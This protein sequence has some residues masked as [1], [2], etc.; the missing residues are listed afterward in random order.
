MNPSNNQQASVL[1][2]L[3]ILVGITTIIFL[4]LSQTDDKFNFINRWYIVV[5]IGVVYLMINWVRTY[6]LVL[7]FFSKIKFF[8]SIQVEYRSGHLEFVEKYGSKAVFNEECLLKKIKRKRLYEGCITATGNILEEIHT[9]NCFNSLNHKKDKITIIYGKKGTPKDKI[10]NHRQLQFGYS[11]TFMDTFIGEKE[12]WG[13]TFTHPTKFYDLKISFHKK[14]PPLNADIF[15]VIK[16]PDGSEKLE[17]LSI[18]PLIIKKYNRVLLKVKLL[19][20]Q[21]G[22][23]I[24]VTWEWNKINTPPLNGGVNNALVGNSQMVDVPPLN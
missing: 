24:R 16:N 15:R 2:S 13:T 7:R 19:H 17:P 21:K 18:D 9:Y 6:N 22:D 1:A 20:V 10:M 5:G 4:I 3:N 14:N 11:I 12:S 8:L 23:Q